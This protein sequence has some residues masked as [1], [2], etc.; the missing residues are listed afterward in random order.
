M[1]IRGVHRSYRSLTRVEKK[2]GWWAAIAWFLWRSGSRTAAGHNRTTAVI[3][4]PPRPRQSPPA[5]S[6]ARAGIWPWHGWRWAWPT[7]SSPFH[8]PSWPRPRSW[9]RPGWGLASP[10]GPERHRWT[11]LGCRPGDDVAG[12]ARSSGHTAHPWLFPP[13]ANEWSS[14]PRTVPAPTSRSERHRPAGW[15]QSPSLPPT[16]PISCG[17]RPDGVR[18]RWRCESRTLHWVS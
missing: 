9:L 7:M 4:L 16:P 15:R 5:P 8:L 1:I 3:D 17:D 6:S 18:P 2:A 14:S 11:S 12:P 10:A 13:G